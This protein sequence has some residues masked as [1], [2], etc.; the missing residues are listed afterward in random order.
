MKKHFIFLILLSLIGCGGESKSTS[1]NTSTPDIKPSDPDTTIPEMNHPPLVDQVE[2]QIIKA[3]SQLVLAIQA[4]DPD[5]DELIYKL[6]DNR[7]WISIDDDGK[8]LINPKSNNIGNYEVFVS[9]SDGKDNTIIIIDLEVI[10]NEI[11][12]PNKLD[13]EVL[14]GVDEE[15]SIMNENIEQ[16]NF[17]LLHH[18][19]IG[20]ISLDEILGAITITPNNSHI[21]EHSFIVRATEINSNN[22]IDIPISIT[23]LK[24]KKESRVSFQFSNKEKSK[25]IQYSLKRNGIKVEEGQTNE[26]I[27]SL[28]EIFNYGDNIDVEIKRVF[29]NQSCSINGNKKSSF[30]AKSNNN[31]V[32]VDCKTKTRLELAYD[33]GEFYLNESLSY[34]YKD[35][36]LVDLPRYKLINTETNKSIIEPSI[37]F[38]PTSDDIATVEINQF[39][40]HKI[41][42]R[43]VGKESI[44]VKPNLMFY[45]NENEATYTLN[46][47]ENSTY[48]RIEFCQINCVEASSRYQ[49]LVGGRE[50]LM[51]MYH[52]NGDY[53]LKIYDETNQIISTKEFSCNNNV[54]ASEPSYVINETC[55]LLIDKNLVNPNIKLDL[56]K[57]NVVVRTLIP[58]IYPSNQ[59]VL[60]LVRFNVQTNEVSEPYIGSFNEKPDEIDDSQALLNIKQLLENKFP[61][62]KI[63]VTVSHNDLHYP[64]VDKLSDVDMGIAHNMLSNL[65]VREIGTAFANKVVYFGLLPINEDSKVNGK[66]TIGVAISK[67]ANSISKLLPT[68]AKC[69]RKPCLTEFSKT[70]VHEIGHTLGLGHA[71]CG[72]P[73]I[74]PTTKEEW[75]QVFWEIG[76]KGV[77]N[78]SPIYNSSTSEVISPFYASTQNPGEFYP[79]V[80][81]M[82]YCNGFQFSELNVFKML[83]YMYD[84]EIFNVE[85]TY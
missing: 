60:N 22:V 54:N 11:Q 63:T 71:P 58:N 64:K 35:K 33:S 43:S 23:V 40:N 57:D 69:N 34:Q 85:N 18:G 7:N 31:I 55:N 74:S 59:L 6:E 48:N 56:V 12:L 80:D 51:R 17:E 68:D 83:N 5:G 27:D 49:S 77:L 65:R 70:M 72:N 53:T 38:I 67:D 84:Q 39:K 8:I 75:N 76:E 2:K 46:I 42:P 24:N 45:D 15:H 9:V 4:S 41:R 79:T 21:G 29:N 14:T 44:D 26:H 1:D 61:F 10:R 3:D 78:N 47:I 32:N 62:S 28:D 37:T 50:V 36:N 25:N 30:I 13:I 81:I 52:T 16:F 66:G 20:L 73:S 19:E 82:G